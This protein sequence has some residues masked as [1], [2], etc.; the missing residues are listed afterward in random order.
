[1]KKYEILE[2]ISDL[3]IRAFGG[4]KEELFL[5]MLSG[6]T[7]SL[8]PEIKE[9]MIIERKIKVSSVDLSALM[10]DFLNE[11]LYL[12]QTKKEAYF[13]GRFIKFSDTRLEADLVGKKVEKFGEDIKAVTYSGLNVARKENGVWESI[14]IFDI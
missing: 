6:M 14:V 2:H 7:E 5:N 11:A 4:T 8:R 12:A 9:D 10:A 1:M 13:E 3:K